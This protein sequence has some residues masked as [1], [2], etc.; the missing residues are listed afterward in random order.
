MLMFFGRSMHFLSEQPTA[1]GGAI[2]NM[3]C[4]FIWSVR[5][6]SKILHYQNSPSPGP[7]SGINPN[8]KMFTNP[9]VRAIKGRLPVFWNM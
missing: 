6:I 8:R 9:W 4:S 7:K 1:A 5:P 2:H 3:V